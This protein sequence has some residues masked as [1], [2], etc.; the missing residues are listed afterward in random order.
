MVTRGMHAR[1]TLIA[2]MVVVGSALSGC[3]TTTGPQGPAGEQGQPGPPGEDGNANVVAGLI[4]LT[5]DDWGQGVY[6]Y[7]PSPGSSTTRGARVVELAVPEIT[8]EVFDLGMVHVYLKVPRV[9][10]GDPVAWAPLPY[11]YLA[12]GGE[13]YY[14]YAFTFEPGVLTL[15]YFHTSTD[16]QTVPPSVTTWT[17]ADSSWKF[18]IATAEAIETLASEGV[19]PSDA[20]AVERHLAR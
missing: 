11:Q 6:A 2:L 1:A 3:G 18:V 7:E 4:E 8:Q 5:N 20:G 9:L 12:F 19:D 15:Y 10:L 14:N 13:F 16:D 17:L